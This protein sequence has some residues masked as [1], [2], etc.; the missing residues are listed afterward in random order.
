MHSVKIVSVL[1]TFRFSLV[2]YIY[3]KFTSITLDWF[4]LNFPAMSLT[5]KTEHS[6]IWYQV[7]LNFFLLTEDCPL[8][9]FFFQ[10]QVFFYSSQLA[11]MS[12]C[13]LGTSQEFYYPAKNFPEHSIIH[14]IS[15]SPAFRDSS[16]L[17]LTEAC[18]QRSTIDFNWENRILII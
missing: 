17:F 3:Y 1:P 4:F 10:S 9:Q 7:L 2:L 18:R 12:L 11:F 13:I 5:L 6:R 8:S 14:S 16:L 15:A